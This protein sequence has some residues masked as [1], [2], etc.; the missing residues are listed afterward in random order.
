MSFE[1]ERIIQSK[2]PFRVCTAW[3][4][5]NETDLIR[6]HNAITENLSGI[7]ENDNEHY[8]PDLLNSLIVDAV[9]SAETLLP[10]SK[11][12]KG[13]KPYWCKQVEEAHT[14]ARY[15]RRK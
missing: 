5:C 7:L 11:F 13:A 4:K 15:M 8:D 2:L 9:H 14:V 3:H 1:T 12:N 10:R 6:Y